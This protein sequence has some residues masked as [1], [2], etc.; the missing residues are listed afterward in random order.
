MSMCRW[1]VV[2]VACVTGCGSSKAKPLAA[3]RG[4]CISPIAFGARVDDGVDDREAIQAAIDEAGRRRAEVCL[5]AGELQVSRRFGKIASLEITGTGV[6][7]RGEGAGSRLSMLD[8]PGDEDHRDWWVIKVSGRDHVLRDFAMDGSAR[9]VTDEQTHLIQIVGPARHVRLEQLALTLPTQTISRGGDCI[10][11]LGERGA[12]V[13]DV[14]I[15][16]V[17]GLKCARSFIAFQRFVSHV[18]LRDVLAVEVKN[19]AIDMEPTGGGAVHDVVIQRSEFRRSVAGSYTI[20]LAGN[21]KVPSERLVI[22][23]SQIEG[24][25]QLF[26]VHDATIHYNRISSDI[27]QRPLIKIQKDS[28]QIRIDS[29]LIERSSSPGPGIELTSHHGLWPTDITIRNNEITMTAGGRA[30]YG[31]PVERIEI[32]DNT[33]DCGHHDGALAAIA[34]RGVL[35]PIRGVRV[36]NNLIRGTCSAAVHLMQHAQNVT[37]DM[38]FEDNVVEGPRMGIVFENGAPSVKPVIDRNV[39]RGLSAR[40]RVIGADRFSGHNSP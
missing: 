7:L 37:G 11:M 31:E 24:S 23:D 2:L 14:S 20:S 8:Q 36:R 3:A 39:F 10:R 13:E 40:E 38:L 35:V 26:R 6:T 9:G 29:N 1:L 32:A 25:I 12:E 22:E 4:E 19:S 21:A 28:K 16:G 27:A 18:L 17:R 33:I 5:P 30:I 15:I 34:L